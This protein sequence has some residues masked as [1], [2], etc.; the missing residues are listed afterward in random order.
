MIQQPEWLDHSPVTEPPDRYSY[1]WSES[2]VEELRE[3]M[4][5][6]TNTKENE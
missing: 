5:A 3:V 1:Y 4:K 2:W 6:T